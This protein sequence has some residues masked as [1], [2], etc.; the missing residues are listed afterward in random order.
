MSHKQMAMIH[1]RKSQTV[2]SLNFDKVQKIDN[3]CDMPTLCMKKWL[4][5]TAVISLLKSPKPLQRK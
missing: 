4:V 2:Q 3:Q 1:E 5:L